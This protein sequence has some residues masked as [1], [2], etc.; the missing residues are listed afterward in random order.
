MQLV[1]IGLDNI[2]MLEEMDM[3]DLS[4]FD[5]SME[6]ITSEDV[7]LMMTLMR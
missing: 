6:E 4:D 3:S 1:I 5:F 7:T 2:E